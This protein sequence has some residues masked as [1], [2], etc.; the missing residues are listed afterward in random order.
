M[1]TFGIDARHWVWGDEDTIT[2]LAQGQ[3]L[4]KLIN[5]SK[6]IVLNAVGHIPQIENVTLFNTRI[7]EA[8][9][10]PPP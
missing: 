10:N 3:Q 1:T 9:N 2:P 5:R 4:Q 8:L 7:V 6:L